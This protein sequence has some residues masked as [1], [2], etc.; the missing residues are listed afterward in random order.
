MTQKEIEKLAIDICNDLDTTVY[1]SEGGLID[2]YDNMEIACRAG[3][4]AGEKRGMKA[5][6]KICEENTQKLGKACA[7]RSLGNEYCWE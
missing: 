4:K 1:N 5:I 6:C 3:I 7:F 2:V